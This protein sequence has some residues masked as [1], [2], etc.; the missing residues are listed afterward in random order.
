MSS[1]R[2]RLSLNVK[3]AALTR[4]GTSGRV[5]C[6]IKSAAS[7]V[8]SRTNPA[9]DPHR[10]QWNYLCSVNIQQ[11]FEMVDLVVQEEENGSILG[12]AKLSLLSVSDQE[13]H[14]EI[15]PLLSASGGPQC[16]TI[17]V[18]ARYKYTS[19]WSGMY[20]GL[21]LTKAQRYEEALTFLNEG[22]SLFPQ[23]IVLLEA[24]IEAS[25]ALQQL[26]NALQDAV[27][28][29]EINPNSSHGYYWIGHV[30]QI[31]GRLEEA[32][33]A[34]NEGLSFNKS[35]T[36]I[37][38]GIHSLF[39]NVAPKPLSGGRTEGKYS[40]V[41]GSVERLFASKEYMEAYKEINL[42]I[43]QTK[44]PTAEHFLSRIF[45]AA[46][47][48]RK[49]TSKATPGLT[50]LDL[51]KQISADGVSLAQV[52]PNWPK[53]NSLKM[54]WIKKGGGF[55]PAKKRR[56]FVLTR[57]LLFYYNSR[58]DNSPNGVIPVPLSVVRKQ[59]A[60]KFTMQVPG[61]TYVMV[62]RKSEHL[63]AWITAIES[64]AAHPMDFP[65]IRAQKESAESPA[66]SRA[67]IITSLRPRRSVMY[68]KES[69][70]VYKPSSTD[71]VREGY[72][73]KTGKVRTSWKRRYF[74]LKPQVLFYFEEQP[75]GPAE[76]LGYIELVDSTC[77]RGDTAEIGQHR[78]DVAT[79]NRVYRLYAI[80]P[81]E[82]NEWMGAITICSDENFGT[83]AL[84]DTPPFA[85]PSAD[86]PDLTHIKE[87]A[88]LVP[89]PERQSLK[90][91]NVE[92]D[93]GFSDRDS[94]ADSRHSSFSDSSMTKSESKYFKK[95]GLNPPE[96]NKA[97]QSVLLTNASG[98][99]GAFPIAP[100]AAPMT[101]TQAPSQ[102][103]IRNSRNYTSAGVTPGETDRL[104]PQQPARRPPPRDE[105][106]CSC[107]LI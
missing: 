67:S 65:H 11:P 61:R 27:R 62:E 31:A 73:Y 105:P 37:L 9:P 51:I 82:M 24:R 107:T 1:L 7:E 59:D 32:K 93:H 8:T 5:V 29:R 75:N 90:S 41:M 26:K 20:K 80:T 14:L 76:P 36:R 60:S 104:I 77:T 43:K 78:F 102:E 48:I 54:G 53:E 2:G 18:E 52:A 100:P 15:L 13:P 19:E 25:L 45:I 6:A 72:L 46:A 3:E 42:M 103:H 47:L 50:Q 71:T 74:I 70:R 84:E 22:L 4:P 39:S 79:H 16:G 10:L 55:N 64:A 106:T 49:T 17:T 83:V 63:D 66:Q 99:L 81:D 98:S 21:E 34:Y 91:L 69:K 12:R 95:F 56:W 44:R 57:P 87:D 101:L 33:K 94:D 86:L 68:K 40:E 88:A 58:E 89:S 23:E 38:E 97:R 30:Y 92:D 28:I 85:A 35:D 96:Q